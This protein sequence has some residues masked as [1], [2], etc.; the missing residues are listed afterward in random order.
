MLTDPRGYFAR[1]RERARAEVER[2][3]AREAARARSR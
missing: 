3:I 2:D 1:A